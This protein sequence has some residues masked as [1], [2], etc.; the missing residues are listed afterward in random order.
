MSDDVFVP[1]EP[2]SPIEIEHG[3]DRCVFYG[4]RG[5]R[6]IKDARVDFRKAKR[7]YQVAM[8]KSRQADKVGSRADRED[9]AIIEHE[10]LWEDM[11]TKEILMKYGED[12]KDD[13]NRELSSLQTDSKLII[14]A[15]QIGGG[16]R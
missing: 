12:K 11:D 15:Q 5:T 10:A 4:K 16:I 14:A 6:T 13:L 8:A 3:M 2:R 7:D 9:R 1:G